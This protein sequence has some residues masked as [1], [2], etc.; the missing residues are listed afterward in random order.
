VVCDH[1]AELERELIRRGIAV[2]SRGR[3]WSAN[4]REWV[5]FDCVL[6]RPALRARLALPEYILDH[7]HTGTHDGCEAGFVCPH[8]HDAVMGLHPDRPAGRPVVS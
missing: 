8:C 2:T 4:C 7:V 3:A 1:L 6:D 5:Y